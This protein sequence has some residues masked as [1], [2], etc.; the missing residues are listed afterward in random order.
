MDHASMYLLN[1]IR[2]KYTINPGTE[3]SNNNNDRIRL[4]S[5]VHEIHRDNCENT[6]QKVASQ[7]SSFELEL[8]E[9]FK[10]R[11]PKSTVYSVGF[12]V[13]SPTLTKLYAQLSRHFQSI[14]D[15]TTSDHI[16]WHTNDHNGY[17]KPESQGESVL[18]FVPR[19]NVGSHFAEAQAES[20]FAELKS[21]FPDGIGTITAIGLN[22]REYYAC[23]QM[24]TPNF[25][26]EYVEF[27]FSRS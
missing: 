3:Y 4:F 12:N 24:R 16:V 17:E 14:S 26:F 9:P 11:N 5:K 8:R 21:K 6:L 2:A 15:E 13:V 23:A 19:V 1:A 25:T 7:Y 18:P 22:S 27:P 20:V 10:N